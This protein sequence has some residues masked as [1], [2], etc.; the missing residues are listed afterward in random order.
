LKAFRS[1]LAKAPRFFLSTKRLLSQKSDC[2]CILI[3]F[4]RC[5]V[6][7]DR[8]CLER[9]ARDN[10]DYYNRNA[11]KVK[12]IL[13]DLSGINIPRLFASN[14][15]PKGEHSRI[16]LIY[17]MQKTRTSCHFVSIPNTDRSLF[18]GPKFLKKSA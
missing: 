12:R 3:Y 7:K 6:F 15:I 10:V 2:S 9:V 1:S 13:A 17:T 18:Y 8:C 11:E 14:S 16:I 5:I 4:V